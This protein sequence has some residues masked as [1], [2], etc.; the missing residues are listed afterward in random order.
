MSKLLRQKNSYLCA[1]FHGNYCL[2]G[3][4]WQDLLAHHVDCEKQQQQKVKPV[5]HKDRLVEI[6]IN[7][8]NASNSFQ[9]L[10]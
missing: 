8:G 3:F 5:E 9:H 1:K 2:H 4:T 7:L 6:E 10:F